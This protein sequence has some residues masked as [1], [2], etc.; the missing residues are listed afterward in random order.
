MPTEYAYPNKEASNKITMFFMVIFM[1]TAFIVVLSGEQRSPLDSPLFCSL[2][3]LTIGTII[4]S[5]IDMEKF[6][7]ATLMTIM[8]NS[9]KSVGKLISLTLFGVLVWSVPNALAL[10]I[11]NKAGTSMV[12]SPIIFGGWLLIA[13]AVVA[14]IPSYCWLMRKVHRRIN[15]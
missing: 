10:Y 12:H 2:S 11:S 1:T 8:G 5:I 7:G 6:I 4:F 3:G 14:L 13:G 15:R 9:K